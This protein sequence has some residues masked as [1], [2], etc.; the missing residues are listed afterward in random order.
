MTRERRL[1][2]AVGL[3]LAVVVVQL[4]GGAVA[5]SLGLLADAA[6]N[7]AIGWRGVKLLGEA[8]GVLLESAPAGVDAM[9]LADTMAAVDGVESVHDLHVWS[10]SS[11]LHALAAHLVL[12]GHPSLEEAQVVG[13][14]VRR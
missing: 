8:A 4:V 11:E 7:A 1:W 10:L 3:N 2:A 5:G 12:D 9:A 14:R 13:D 6:H